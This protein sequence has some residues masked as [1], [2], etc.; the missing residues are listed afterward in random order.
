LVKPP[1]SA[2]GG[3][4]RYATISG[5]TP[6]DLEDEIKRAYNLP[7][8]KDGSIIAVLL[9]TVKGA[10]GINLFTCRHEHMYEPY[11]HYA[12]VEQFFDRAI[13][14]G[15]LNML[16]EKDRTVFRYVYLSDY[17]KKIEVTNIKSKGKKPNVNVKEDV[18]AKEDVNVD[19]LIKKNKEL[20]SMESTTDVTLYGRAVQ[21][22][23]LRRSFMYAMQEASIDCNIHYSDAQKDNNAI[24]KI[25][26]RMCLPTNKPLYVADLRKDMRLPSPCEAT[27]KEKLK[28]KSITVEHRD[29]DNAVQFEKEYMYNIEDSTLHIYEFDNKLNGY[30]EIFSSDPEYYDVYKAIKNKEKKIM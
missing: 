8:N 11:W 30:T 4:Y 5:D 7:E 22:N 3:R 19:D 27:A 16:P 26:C 21:N 14:P 25:K 28:V 18:N 13:R 20:Q 9:V 23:I 6:P 10:E 2:S 12:R 29:D 17:P 15:S 24:H 1:T